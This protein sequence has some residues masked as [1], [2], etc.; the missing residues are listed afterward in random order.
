MHPEKEYES[1]L[2]TEGIYVE[3]LSFVFV[4]FL[5]RQCFAL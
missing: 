1:M 2:K 4:V 5:L 3:I